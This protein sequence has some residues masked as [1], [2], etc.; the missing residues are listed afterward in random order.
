MNTLF[1]K[2]GRNYKSMTEFLLEHLYCFDQYSC[3]MCQQVTCCCVE[4]MTIR[5][6]SS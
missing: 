4:W 6:R 2:S 1:A 3:G 5:V